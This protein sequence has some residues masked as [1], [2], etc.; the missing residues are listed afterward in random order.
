MTK[1]ELHCKQVSTSITF[2]SFQKG[3]DQ[4]ALRATKLNYSLDLIVDILQEPVIVPRRFPSD[5]ECAL[6]DNVLTRIC[7]SQVSSLLVEH[8]PRIPQ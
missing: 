4:T 6:G 2:A 8:L 1:I 3:F 5:A 7:V